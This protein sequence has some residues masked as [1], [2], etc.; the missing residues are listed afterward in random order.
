MST[1]GAIIVGYDGSDRGQDVLAM[2]RRLAEA[3]GDRLIVTCIHPQEAAHSL[4][5][6]D[7]EWVAYLHEQATETIE[8]AKAV[9]GAPAGVDTVY[10]VRAA[11]SASRGLDGLAEEYDADTIV[12]GSSRRDARRRARPGS[13]GHRL[14]RG[15]KSAIMLA[16]R[17][18]RDTSPDPLARIGCAYL[19]TP[20]GHVALQRAISRWPN[21]AAR[22]CT[23]TRSA[24][25]EQNGSL[26]WSARTSTTATYSKLERASRRPWTGLWVRSR[27]ESRRRP[28][29]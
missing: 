28:P 27:T 12:I 21:A 1:P 11:S 14:L 13:T 19:D 5:A 9:P 25:A 8:E 26:R 6:L 23:S 29:C 20:D 3:S 18:Y 22:L 17:N 7:T 4:G 15:S 16:P 2:G 10:E 24:P